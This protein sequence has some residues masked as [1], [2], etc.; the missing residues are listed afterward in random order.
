[1]GKPV[2]EP[3]KK[4][5][6]ELVQEEPVPGPNP[7]KPPARMARKM[8]LYVGP[9]SKVT[10]VEG[11]S[12]GTQVDKEA[13]LVIS[14]PLLIARSGDDPYYQYFMWVCS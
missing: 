12:L 11:A 14:R 2:K 6:A 1:M 4:P 9:G 10:L 8:K 3:V 5:V 13:N 7:S